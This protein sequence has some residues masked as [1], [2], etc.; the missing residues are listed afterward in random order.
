MSVEP[1]SLPRMASYD[2]ITALVSEQI[3]F[4]PYA[5]GHGLQTQTADDFQQDIAL[6]NKV[7]ELLNEEPSMALTNTVLLAIQHQRND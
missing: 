1:G 4:F 7:L 5:D 3:K 2:D 6:G